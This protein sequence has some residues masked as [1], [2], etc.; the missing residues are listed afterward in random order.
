MGS[1]NIKNNYKVYHVKAHKPCSS[2]IIDVM[3]KNKEVIGT[4]KS[5]GL[6]WYDNQWIDVPKLIETSKDLTEENT[7]LVEQLDLSQRCFKQVNKNLMD[8][9]IFNK[10]LEHDY[11]ILV[12]KYNKRIDY[13]LISAFVFGCLLAA[14]V[15][16]HS[17]FKLL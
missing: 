3:D 10:D 13:I 11:E 1:L 12:E 7:R 15:I 16:I 8:C 5:S 4:I 6:V 9:K 17:I 14:I 2:K